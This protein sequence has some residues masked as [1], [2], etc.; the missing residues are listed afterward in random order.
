MTPV[1]NMASS[2]STT[3][4]VIYNQARATKQLRKLSSA[5]LRTFAIDLAIIGLGLR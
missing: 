3:I 4:E 2:F 5:K 1:T